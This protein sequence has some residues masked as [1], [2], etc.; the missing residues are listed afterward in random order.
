QPFQVPLP[1]PPVARPVGVDASGAEIYRITARVA[2]QEILPG[3]ATTIFG[4]DGIFP[5]PTVES[6]RNRPIVIEHRNELPVPTVV[7]LHGGHTPAE[8]DGWPLDLILPTRG[9]HGQPH[10]PGM[11]GDVTVGARQYRYPLDQPAATL[12]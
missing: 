2:E 4:Y 5:G 8:H 11:L 9:S 1:I 10:H 3:L 7:H 12:W 6:R